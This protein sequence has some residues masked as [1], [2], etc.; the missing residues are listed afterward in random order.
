MH[1]AWHHLLTL[2]L[3]A[4]PAF[5]LVNLAWLPLCNWMDWRLNR[6]RAL[7]GR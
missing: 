5:L 1:P 3:A 6:D 7:D 4:V 2:F